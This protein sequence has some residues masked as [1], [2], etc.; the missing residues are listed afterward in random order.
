[1][2][3]WLA[4]GCIRALLGADALGEE[5]A[6][7]QVAAMLVARGLEA[8]RA[9]HRESGQARAVFRIDGREI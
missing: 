2:D 4:G 8:L 6:K 7:Q 3:P 5:G 9:L 1:M